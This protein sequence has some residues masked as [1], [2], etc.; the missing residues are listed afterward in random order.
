MRNVWKA[1][2]HR[3]SSIR[4]FCLGMFYPD[5]RSCEWLLPLHLILVLIALPLAEEALVLCSTCSVLWIYPQTYFIRRHLII[6][7]KIKHG[8]KNK[9]LH[10]EQGLQNVKMMVL[11]ITINYLTDFWIEWTTKSIPVSTT[12]L[13]HKWEMN[14]LTRGQLKNN[15]VK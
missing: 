5:S 13:H 10:R 4:N 12:F 6:P 9:L 3:G 1:V 2:R 7:Q 11:F 14:E 15:Q 8:N